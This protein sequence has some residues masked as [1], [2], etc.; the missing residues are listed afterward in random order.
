MGA[1]GDRGAPGRVGQTWVDD[2]PGI[3]SK[4]SDE[5]DIQPFTGGHPGMMI[6]GIGAPQRLRDA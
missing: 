5:T 4:A 2:T 6:R 1:A 3:L